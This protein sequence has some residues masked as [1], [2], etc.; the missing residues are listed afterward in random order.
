MHE[1]YIIFPSYSSVR[2]CSLCIIAIIITIIIISN[3][4][5]VVIIIIIIVI[6]ITIT[7]LIILIIL[8]ILTILIIII[9]SIIIIIT[10][11]IIIVIIVIIIVC[12]MNKRVWIV[13]L[14]FGPTVC[15]VDMTM[16][17]YDSPVGLYCLSHDHSIMS[18]LHWTRTAQ[19]FHSLLR[20]FMSTSSR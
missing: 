11:I 17:R 15:Y 1:Y 16:I 4:I 2:Q 13:S 14:L 8:I 18:R 3:I 12:R 6:I 5:I 19:S 20:R 7:I 10:I 9:I